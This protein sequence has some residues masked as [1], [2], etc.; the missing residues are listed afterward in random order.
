MTKYKIIKGAETVAESDSRLEIGVHFD[1]RRMDL[2]EFVVEIINGK[3]KERVSVPEFFRR[4]ALEIRE[5][6]GLSQAVFARQYGIPKR[7]V[8]NWESKTERNSSK[9]PAYVLALLERAVRDDYG[10]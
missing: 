2:G 9:A 7:S 3:E 6:T 10:P 5:L 1:V 8:E 4:W